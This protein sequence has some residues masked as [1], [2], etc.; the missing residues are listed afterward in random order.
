MH[1]KIVLVM[2]LVMSTSL[3]AKETKLKKGLLERMVQPKVSLNSSYLSD[4]NIN[5]SDGSV[6]VAKNSIRINN[7]IGGITYTNWSFLWNNVADLPF[8]NG[9][10]KPI[11]QM[12]RLKLN[13]TLPYFISDKWF[14]ITSL[15]VNTTF[16]KEMKSSYGTGIFSF[17]SYKINDDHAIQMG[18]FANYHPVSTLA[19]PVIS[20]SYRARKT[21]GLQVILGFPRAFVGY[22]IND[23]LLLRGGMVF[24]QSVIK[25]SNESVIESSGYI[26]AEDYMGNIGLVYEVSPSFTLDTDLLYSLKRNFTIYNSSGDEQSAYSIKPSFGVSMRLKY[27]F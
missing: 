16:E 9:L 4:A 3:F 10:D 5:G 18:A 7:A 14:L 26:E 23:D 12:H 2:V 19:L 27:L 21:D 6:Q 1:K 11:K 25:L 20:Y 17:A 22:F 24:S 8:G 13:A 15:S